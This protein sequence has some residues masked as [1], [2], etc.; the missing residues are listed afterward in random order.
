MALIYAKVHLRQG[1]VRTVFIKRYLTTLYQLYS[2]LKLD[3]LYPQSMPGLFLDR[4]LTGF[5]ERTPFSPDRNLLFT[6]PRY[7]LVSLADAIR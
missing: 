1:V 6:T 5:F 7:E 2:I 3:V 4:I